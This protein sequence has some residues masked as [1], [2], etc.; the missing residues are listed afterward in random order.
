MIRKLEKVFEKSLKKVL[1]S[2]K[3]CDIIHKRCRENGNTKR[4]LK[5]KQRLKEQ[6]LEDS[7][8]S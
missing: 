6:T 8:R 5:I 4:T 2:E 7:F 1:T 3:V